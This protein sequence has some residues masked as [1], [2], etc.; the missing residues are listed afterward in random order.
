MEPKT[1]LAVFEKDGWRSE[2]AA[3]RSRDCA[4]ERC[5]AYD[6]TK[7]FGERVA[8]VYLEGE[9]NAVIRAS[10]ADDCWDRKGYRCPRV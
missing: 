1:V 2:P 3:V 7:R 5:D 9:R 6:L 4:P 10:A 8:E